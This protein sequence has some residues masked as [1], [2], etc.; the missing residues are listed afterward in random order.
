MY[1]G[2][3]WFNT[4]IA[5]INLEHSTHV[6]ITLVTILWIDRFYF[7]VTDKKLFYCV[8]LHENIIL[9]AVIFTVKMQCRCKYKKLRSQVPLLLFLKKNY[10]HFSNHLQAIQ[11]HES[12]YC[13]SISTKSI[14]ASLDIIIVYQNLWIPPGVWCKKDSWLHSMII[15]SFPYCGCMSKGKNADKWIL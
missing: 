7:S 9:F 14:E 3:F 15:A 4:T 5:A 13:D 11:H 1:F 6:R 8:C 12:F 2:C 10:N